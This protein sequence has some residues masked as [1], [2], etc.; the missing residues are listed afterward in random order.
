MSEVQLK[1]RIVQKLERMSQE[2][3]AFLDNFIDSLDS[4]LQSQSIDTV[5]EEL[6]NDQ[7]RQF[8][9]SLRGKY[10]RAATS[11]SE[12]AH[13]KQEEIDWEERHR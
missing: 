1:Q 9:R 10:A 4:Y 8:I 3:L 12:F 6:S 5:R 2:K 13:R 7:R 11:S